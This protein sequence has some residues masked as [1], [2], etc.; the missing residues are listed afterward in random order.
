MDDEPAIAPMVAPAASSPNRRLPC[1]L[2]NT[3]TISAQNSDT[4]NRLK[5]EVQ[6]KKT[7][8]I[9]GSSAAGVAAS[10][11]AKA[12]RFAA[13]NRYAAGRKRSRGMRRTSAEKAGLSASIATSVAVNS[14]CR[15]S[16]PPSTPISSRIGR[17]T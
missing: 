11:T 10:A 12:T 1:S 13:K 15:F 7:R 8:P 6:T 4:T 5:T 14:H 2:S 16:T 17:I 3:S 9:H